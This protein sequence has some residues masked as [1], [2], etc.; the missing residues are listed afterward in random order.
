[1]IITKSNVLLGLTPTI[2][3]GASANDEKN[4]TDPDFSTS[5]ISSN[6]SQLVANFGAIGNISYV[7]VAGINVAATNNQGGITVLD[8]STVIKTNFIVRNNCVVITFDT[9]T[10]TELNIKL[11]NQNA[12]SNPQCHFMAAGLHFEAPNSG[13]NSGYN[14]QFLNRN[15][16][17]KTATNESAAPTA[18]LRN[19][20]SAKGTLKLPNVTKAFSENEWQDFLDFA[21]Y[22]YFFIRENDGDILSETTVVNQSAYLCYEIS[23][24]TVTAHS[25]T[26]A[27][28]DINVNFKVFN[29]L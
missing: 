20:V 14:R 15:F 16:K 13:E 1:M 23:K 25:S 4:L 3:V 10:F 2:S 22:N 26:R 27:L 11:F 9:R 24:N 12:S 6:Q 18:V 21:F 19:K 28:N 29:G 8:G 17:N 7:A 5:Y